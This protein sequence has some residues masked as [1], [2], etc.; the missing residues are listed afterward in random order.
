MRTRRLPSATSLEL[1]TFYG[2]LSM[3]YNS[4]LDDAA[5]KSTTLRKNCRSI[6]IGMGTRCPLTIMTPPPP[7]DLS[8]GTNGKESACNAGEPSLILGL[9]RS[10][11]KGHGHP[12]QY[13]CLEN[14]R[15]KG[16]WQAAVHGVTKSR[17]QLTD[18]HVSV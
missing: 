1:F 18:Q 15:D 10:P 2:Y 7:C 3:S 12:P 9:G 13:S 6:S 11:G 8:G 16:A 4:N 17:T 5:L 14:S